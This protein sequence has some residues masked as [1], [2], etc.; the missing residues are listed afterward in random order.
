VKKIKELQSLFQQLI[1]RMR[2]LTFEISSPLLYKIGLEAAVEKLTEQ[3]Q[4]RHRIPCDFID[5]R[6]NKPLDEDIGILLFQMVR[7]L[8]TNVIK[9]AQAKHVGVYINKHENDI[10]IV[11][12]DDGIGIDNS[13]SYYCNN[14]GFG[15][16]SINERLHYISGRMEIKTKQGGGTR[17]VLLAPL[18]K[19]PELTV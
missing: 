2:S 3:I 14:E 8:L 17:V 10:C 1:D 9:H 12:E 5:D 16:F 7:E 15:L 6:Q 11:V 18:K 13:K 19:E 4:E